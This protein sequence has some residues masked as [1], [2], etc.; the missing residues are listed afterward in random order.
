MVKFPPTRIKND[1]KC[2]TTEK[3]ETWQM[4]IE[5]NNINEISTLLVL[6]SWSYSSNNLQG[7]KIYDITYFSNT[8]TEFN[9]MHN[10]VL[11]GILK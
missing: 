6:L 11:L 4:R 1:E 9:L 10:I 5:I 3:K 8:I 2:S 7:Y